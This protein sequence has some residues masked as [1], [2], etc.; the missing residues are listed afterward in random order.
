MASCQLECLGFDDSGDD[1][2]GRS[3][4]RPGGPWARGRGPLRVPGTE[5]ES[6]QAAQ[7]LALRS[8]GVHLPGGTVVQ[9]PGRSDHDQCPRLV[10]GGP[11]F[12]G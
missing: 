5:A 6:K 12:G 8:D 7:R 4:A 1:P 9:P 10:P 3:W 11:G 2:G